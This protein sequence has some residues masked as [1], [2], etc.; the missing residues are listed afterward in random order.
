MRCYREH[1]CGSKTQ[2]AP[3]INTG[4]LDSD[5][6]H[7]RVWLRTSLASSAVQGAF[8]SRAATVPHAPRPVRIGGP[9]RSRARTGI[10]PHLRLR[11]P[12]VGT[13]LLGCA[14]RGLAGRRTLMMFDWTSSR[15]VRRR[16]SIEFSFSTRCTTGTACPN[17]NAGLCLGCSR[18]RLRRLARLIGLRMNHTTRMAAEAQAL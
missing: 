15:C 1:S 6:L 7:G 12:M 2:L 11:W 18:D 17:Q 16:S 8:W 3:A 14:Q 4:I 9:P 10:W 13:A 5:P